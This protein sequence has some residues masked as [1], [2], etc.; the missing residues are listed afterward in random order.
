MSANTESDQVLMMPNLTDRQRQILGLVVRGYIED[1][2]AIGSKTL[3]ARYSLSVSS[4]TVRNELARLTE[5]GYIGQPHTSG[6]RVPTEQGYRYFV[7][8]LVGDFELPIFEQQ[9]IRH[10]FHQ[11][12]IEM[13]QWM[14]LAAAILAN[15]SQ[16]ASFVTPPRPRFNRYKHVELVSTR[17]RLVLMILVLYGGQVE[18]QM[19]TLATPLSQERLRVAA[20]E[21]NK[22][23]EGRNLDEIV[24]QFNHLDTLEQD[25]TRLVI[26]IMRRSNHKSVSDI[27]RDGISNILDDDGTR[28]AVR[29]LE[30]RSLLNNVVS[31]AFD[32][33]RTGVQVIIGGEG[34]WEEL[35]HCTLIL[36]RYGV[37]DD[38]AGEVAVV[39]SMRMPYGRNISAVRYVSDLM[40]GFVHEYYAEDPPNREVE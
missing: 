29:M 9:T 24:G 25:V 12:R 15:L 18:Q 31:D 33:K 22:R 17:G 28:H 2:S 13:E 35:K 16:G 38:L 40:S 5:M 11:A 1:G 3:V 23:F 6:G 36:S 8:R 27:Y 39:G 19:L 4:A 14:R 21:L 7:Q 37:D 10:Q 32:E 20:D 30:E 34:R 26:D